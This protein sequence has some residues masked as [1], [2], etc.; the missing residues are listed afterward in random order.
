MSQA[1]DRSSADSAP[2]VESISAP[3]R[4]CTNHKIA[5]KKNLDNLRSIKNKEYNAIILRHLQALLGESATLERFVKKL[6]KTCRVS[7]QFAHEIAAYHG[8][9]RAKSKVLNLLR[10]LQTN[11]AHLEAQIFRKSVREDEL[12]ELE[13]LIDAIESEPS[14]EKPRPA[15]ESARLRKFTPHHLAALL[16]RVLRQFADSLFPSR[17]LPLYSLL[18]GLE[19]D[20][21]GHALALVNMLMPDVN[22]QLLEQLLRLLR[23]VVES[24]A[25]QMSA[26]AIAV[27]FLPTLFAPPE[28]LANGFSSKPRKSRAEVDSL[29]AQISLRTD[30]L[31]EIIALGAAPFA[32]ESL[33]VTDELLA[34]YWRIIDGPA[35]DGG[36]SA[37]NAKNRHSKQLLR[38]L[39]QSKAEA[40]FAPEK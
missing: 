23:R 14:A 17:L 19:R 5:R 1:A 15:S 28:K 20:K 10:L 4:D 16:K 35:K 33:P 25:S 32:C 40:K 8:L 34:L 3:P 27:V 29:A 2:K 24:P 37:K 39:N 11:D 12:V 6:T 21:F 18:H 26:R 9:I 30:V 36:A 22:K 31:S 7:A 13:A 38:S